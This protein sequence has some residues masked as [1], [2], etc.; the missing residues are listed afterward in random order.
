L[1]WAFIVI[2]VLLIP[3]LSIVLDSQLGRALA[4]RIERRSLGGA[5]EL[6]ADRIAS[7]EGEIERLS[8]EVRRLDDEGQFLQRLLAE[9]RDAA[10]REIAA[11]QAGRDAEGRALPPGTQAAAGSERRD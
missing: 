3:V 4:A 2:L 5:Q 11:R 8:S 10:G 9:G 7:L 6:L 1:I